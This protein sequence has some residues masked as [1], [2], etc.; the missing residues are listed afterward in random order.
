MDL[1][2]VN[3]KEIEGDMMVRGNLGHSDHEMIKFSILREKRMGVSITDILD[4]G[5]SVKGPGC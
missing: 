1:F 2:F 3:R 4:L 5:R